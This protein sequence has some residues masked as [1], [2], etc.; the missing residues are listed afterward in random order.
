MPS[1]IQFIGFSKAATVA[2]P[3]RKELDASVITERI[4]GFMKRVSE[5]VV[6]LAKVFSANTARITKHSKGDAVRLQTHAQE[7]GRPH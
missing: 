7:F 4:G 5:D 2:G 1:F 3:P 6:V